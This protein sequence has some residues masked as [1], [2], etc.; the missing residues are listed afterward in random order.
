MRF[1]RIK[2][3]Y[4]ENKITIQQYY[5]WCYENGCLEYLN[6]DEEIILKLGNDFYNKISSMYSEED[7]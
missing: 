1:T 5:E 6:L 3:L 4:E 7:Y 2:K